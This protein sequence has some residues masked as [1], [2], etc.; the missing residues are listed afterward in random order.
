V[1]D[2][3]P[4]LGELEREVMLLVWNHGPI[5]AEA[6]R[7]KLTRALKESTVRTVLRRLEDKGYVL[8]TVE[9]R[10]FHFI[11]A[12]KRGAVAARAVQKILDWFTNGSLEEMLVGMVDNKRLDP[13]QLRALSDKIAKARKK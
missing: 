4:D 6:V 5:T 9:G 8:H 13:K 7:E 2:E 10:T 1:P 3:L 12:E 11:A